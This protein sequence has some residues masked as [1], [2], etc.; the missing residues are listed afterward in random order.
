M[1]LP[2]ETGFGY[3][4]PFGYYPFGYP[5]YQPYTLPEYDRP[6]DLKLDG[7]GDL[8]IEQDDLVL[9][10]GGEAI[11]QDVQIR[12]RFFRGEW[13]LDTRIGVPYYEEILG[14]KPRLTLI[15]GI[16][17]QAILSSPGIESISDLTLDFDRASRLLTVDF[18]ADTITG[19]TLDFVE[20]LIIL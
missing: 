8:A 18:S 20:E 2:E 19:E 4:V 7:S 1:S 6:V 11:R 14:Q 5:D 9:L 17:R 13:F 10:E 3:G 16:F 15:K 12:L